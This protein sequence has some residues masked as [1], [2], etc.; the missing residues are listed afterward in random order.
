MTSSQPPFSLRGPREAKYGPKRGKRRR[1]GR[2]ASS[3]TL[4]KSN[5]WAYFTSIE[6]VVQDQIDVIAAYA[7]P[8]QGDKLQPI[9]YVSYTISLTG[10]ISSNPALT[11]W[12][13]SHNPQSIPSQTPDYQI[14]PFNGLKSD[15]VF[16]EYFDTQTSGNGPLIFNIALVNTTH[17]AGYQMAGVGDV[18]GSSVA[19][20][21][22]YNPSTGDV[23]EW[24]IANG[25]WAASVDLGTHPGNYQIAGLGNFTGGG[26]SGILWLDSS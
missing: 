11:S 10:Q 18:T 26:T 23:D 14:K 1:S 2:R 19:D 24:Q 13:R 3:F 15:S 21:I 8:N 9:D 22:W 12:I 20:I 16:T 17:P 5:T 4:C 7:D 6:N 25:K